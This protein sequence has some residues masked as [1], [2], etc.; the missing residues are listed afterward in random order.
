MLTLL[1]VL[2]VISST[3][4]HGEMGLLSALHNFVVQVS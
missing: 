4:I 2:L 1:T 3:E